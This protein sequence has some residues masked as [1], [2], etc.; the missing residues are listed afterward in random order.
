MDISKAYNSVSS[1]ILE[2][3]MRRIKLPNEFINLVM[4]IAIGRFNKVIVGS[5]NMKNIM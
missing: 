5:E 4:D 1:I 2:R 3:A